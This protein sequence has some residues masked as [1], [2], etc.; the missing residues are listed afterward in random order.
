MGSD[1]I[2]DPMLQLVERSSGIIDP[3]LGAM[4]RTCLLKVTLTTTMDSHECPGYRAV[5]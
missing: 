2:K 3:T 1:W 4:D 5:R